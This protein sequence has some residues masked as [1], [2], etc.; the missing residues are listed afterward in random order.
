M[1]N[2]VSDPHRKSFS[3]IDLFELFLHYS[4]RQTLINYNFRD[5]QNCNFSEKMI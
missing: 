3:K 4:K 5:V 1:E 2:A